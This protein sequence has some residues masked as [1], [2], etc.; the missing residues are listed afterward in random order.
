MND[1][2]RAADEKIMVN[3]R[4]HLP[5]CRAALWQIRRGMKVMGGDGREV[6]F[7]AAVIVRQAVDSVTHLLLGR[8][9]VTPD[10]RRVPVTLVEDV[11]ED[12]VYLDISHQA[13]DKLAVHQ[14]E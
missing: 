2:V 9:P 1:T 12:T 13:V 4:V 5:R 6:G 11:D 10:Y 7:V 14:P 8:I 3:G